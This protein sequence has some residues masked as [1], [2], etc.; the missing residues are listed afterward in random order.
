MLIIRS[1]E[2]QSRS[3]DPKSRS[4]QT[5]QGAMVMGLKFCHTGREG[6][7]AQLIMRYLPKTIITIPTREGGPKG[8]IE[9]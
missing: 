7:S 9:T 8:S 2:P 4:F 6:P 3:S 1:S 5:I